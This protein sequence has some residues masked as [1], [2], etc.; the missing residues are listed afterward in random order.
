MGRYRRGGGWVN[1]DSVE[2]AIWRGAVRLRVYYDVTSEPD[3]LVTVRAVGI[4]DRNQVM[5]G[6]VQVDL[7]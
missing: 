6:G 1:S 2:E 7:S 5:I 3:P 4:K